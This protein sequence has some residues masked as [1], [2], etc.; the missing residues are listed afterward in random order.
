MVIFQKINQLSILSIYIV[1]LAWGGVAER[2]FFF[3]FFVV[4]I[5]ETLEIFEM[6][7]MSFLDD[8]LLD[9][10]WFEIKLGFLDSGGEVE[11]GGNSDG[12]SHFTSLVSRFQ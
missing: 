10:C 9:A 2:D 11:I 4:S 12:R 1:V 7:L 6:E 5:V 8:V 3:T